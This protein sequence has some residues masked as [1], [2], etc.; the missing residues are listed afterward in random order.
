MDGGEVP[1]S[2]DAETLSPL[3]LW[4]REIWILEILSPYP[5]YGLKLYPG[6]YS[7]FN[8]VDI[9]NPI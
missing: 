3:S 4:L 5:P 9:G 2:G 1:L 6:F 8:V 7:N